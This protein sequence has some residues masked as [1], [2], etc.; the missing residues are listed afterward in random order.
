M[1][2][3]EMPED[4]EAT[5]ETLEVF[6][7]TLNSMS[8]CR[9]DRGDEPQVWNRLVNELQRLQLDLRQTEEG[10]AGISGLMDGDDKTV[11]TWCATFALFWDEPRA[12]AVLQAEVTAKGLA[13]FES[14]IALREFDA[15]RLNTTWQP[16]KE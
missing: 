6:A 7:A 8:Q 14:E 9:V 13:G 10:R 11:R 12:R 15:G 4:L 5:R 1:Q 2:N 16:P 3:G